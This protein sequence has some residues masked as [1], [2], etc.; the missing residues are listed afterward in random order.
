MEPLMFGNKFEMTDDLRY[1]RRS[2]A[3]QGDG[4]SVDGDLDPE[5]EDDE[6]ED[7]DEPEDDEPKLEDDVDEGDDLDD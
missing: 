2:A 4:F 5:I 6:D 7:G 1:Y 3:E